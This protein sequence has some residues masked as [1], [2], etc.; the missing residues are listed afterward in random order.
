MAQKVITPDPASEQ[1]SSKKISKSQK[2]L[3]A[4]SFGSIV[5]SL[6]RLQ[7]RLSKHERDTRHNQ[8]LWCGAARLE[9]W[10]NAYTVSAAELNAAAA[11]SF[12]RTFSLSIVNAKG[13]NINLCEGIA[14][15]LTPGVTAVDGDIG[16]PSVTGTPSFNGAG[17]IIGEIT[18]DT[19]AGSTKT[20]AVDDTVT[21][22]CD[23]TIGGNALDQVTVT[24]TVV[25]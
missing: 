22:D 6:D 13:E 17:R 24:W 7:K 4:Y 9:L 12:K 8:S 16:A 1:E 23:L 15:T 18:F 14:P 3:A 11:D 10:K 5:S 2:R 19:D 21:V 20:Y 25:A